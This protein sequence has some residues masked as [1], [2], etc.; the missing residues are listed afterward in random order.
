MI[1]ITPKSG[2]IGI[3]EAPHAV[4]TTG[5]TLFSP[6]FEKP[7]NELDKASRVAGAYTG[8]F[9]YRWQYSAEDD[10]YLLVV[11]YYK[12]KTVFAV[13]FP[14][15]TAGQVLQALTDQGQRIFTLVLKFKEG[16]KNLFED[17]IVLMGLELDIIPEAGWPV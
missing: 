11:D 12:G 17:A 9:D 7:Y 4:N 16:S 1:K 5:V 3:I 6:E 2:S 15:A 14:R 13:Q 8:K 10:A